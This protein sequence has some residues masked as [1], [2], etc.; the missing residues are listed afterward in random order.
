M[1]LVY[2]SYSNFKLIFDNKLSI[3]IFATYYIYDLLFLLQIGY[4]PIESGMIIATDLVSIL[5]LKCIKN[6]CFSGRLVSSRVIGLAD[7]KSVVSRNLE[8]I[9]EGNQPCPLEIT[10]EYSSSFKT[11]KLNES[12]PSKLSKLSSKHSKPSNVNS[13][14]LDSC[15]NYSKQSQPMFAYNHTNS[16]LNDSI[17][18]DDWKPFDTQSNDA[19]HFE[20]A[21]KIFNRI[22]TDTASKNPNLDLKTSIDSNKYDYIYSM[23]NNKLETIKEF[24]SS[25]EKSSYYTDSMN[26]SNSPDI[27]AINISRQNALISPIQTPDSTTPY[28]QPQNTLGIDQPHFGGSHWDEE[29]QINTMVPIKKN[30]IG[31]QG[32]SDQQVVD[33][34]YEVSFRDLNAFKS[35]HKLKPGFNTYNSLNTKH[36]DPKQVISTQKFDTDHEIYQA[37]DEGFDELD[38]KKEILNKHTNLDLSNLSS[39]QSPHLQNIETNTNNLFTTAPPFKQLLPLNLRNDLFNK[40]AISTDTYSSKETANRELVNLQDETKQKNPI[41][42]DKKELKIRSSKHNTSKNQNNLSFQDVFSAHW[43]RER[44]HDKSYYQN[45]TMSAVDNSSG[46][47]SPVTD[48][49]RIKHSKPKSKSQYVPRKKSCSED[50]ETNRRVSLFNNLTGSTA[51]KTPQLFRKDLNKVKNQNLRTRQRSDD[52]MITGVVMNVISDIISLVDNGIIILDNNLMGIYNNIDALYSKQLIKRSNLDEI[53]NYELL[54]NNRVYTF[55]RIFKKENVTHQTVDFFSFQ[56]ILKIYDFCKKKKGNEW[57]LVNI[58]NSIKKLEEKRNSGLISVYNGEVIEDNNDFKNYKN[59]QQINVIELN[60]LL[61]ALF[62]FQTKSTENGDFMTEN[63]CD[64]IDQFSH[65]S[66]FYKDVSIKLA[67]INLCTEPMLCLT[68]MDLGERV[69]LLN[70][71]DKNKFKN[72]QIS[73]ISHELQTPMNFTFAI[74]DYFIEETRKMQEIFT[75]TKNTNEAT[76]TFIINQ[77]TTKELCDSLSSIKGNSEA[78][79]KNLTHMGLIIQSIVDYSHIQTDQFIMTNESVDIVASI[80]DILKIYSEQTNGKNIFVKVDNPKPT[81]T[82]ITDKKRLDVLLSVIIFNSVKYTMTGKISVNINPEPKLGYLQISVTDTGVGM[83]AEQLKTLK[84]SLTNTLTSKTTTNC[85]GIGL[86][87]RIVATILRYMA[88]KDKNKQE[89]KSE[90]DVGT[91]VTFYLKTGYQ[92]GDIEQG[93]LENTNTDE[94]I[95]ENV[96]P[97]IIMANKMYFKNEIKSKEGA[98]ESS[99]STRQK[100]VS[101]LSP[102][103]KIGLLNENFL[104][105]KNHIDLID[106]NISRLQSPLDMNMDRMIPIALSVSPHNLQHR[107]QKQ[108]FFN[109]AQ[110]I[111]EQ[112]HEINSSDDDAKINII[113]R[114]QKN[115]TKTHTYDNNNY[116]R[117]SSINPYKPTKVK[118]YSGFYV[119][120]RSNPTKSKTQRSFSQFKKESDN[121]LGAF[122]EDYIGSNVI[123]SEETGNNQGK[124]SRFAIS[125]IKRSESEFNEEKSDALSNQNSKNSY[126][127]ESTNGPPIINHKKKNTAEVVVGISQTE[128]NKQIDLKTRQISTDFINNPEI[129]FQVNSDQ[130]KSYDDLHKNEDK[131]DTGNAKILINTIN[132]NGDGIDESKDITVSPNKSNSYFLTPTNKDN[133]LIELL[134]PMNQTNNSLKQKHDETQTFFNEELA[135]SDINNQ[136]Y[137]QNAMKLSNTSESNNDFKFDLEG[138]FKEKGLVLN[139]TNSI[140]LEETLQSNIPFSPKTHLSNQIHQNT[141][142]L[143]FNTDKRDNNH[144]PIQSKHEQIKQISKKSGDDTVKQIY[145][146]QEIV[147]PDNKIKLED[148]TIRKVNTV[149]SNNP[150]TSEKYFFVYK[151]NQVYQRMQAS[152]HSFTCR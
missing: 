15:E 44:R 34:R 99:L 30:V 55:N 84:L 18:G 47:N 46:F 139:K 56:T 71:D 20:L 45:F 129:T 6:C 29:A 62:Q 68:I 57:F 133:T 114:D 58:E 134:G 151:K 105:T 35:A 127:N 130:E 92:I 54:V 124:H 37:D 109:K 108:I 11:K 128:K 116:Q 48:S 81:V 86:G 73:S 88:P 89:F 12:D 43:I 87:L 23:N 82:W 140:L 98:I 7:S 26:K 120:N 91:T 110:S 83:S 75:D 74:M 137:L 67:F 138:I 22:N 150:G 80:K 117:N 10:P 36:T 96:I 66:F 111:K 39:S 21:K 40:P 9:V 77:S 126:S 51:S 148:A 32:I 19:N 60:H 63:E 136:N 121:T 123:N 90:K 143:L 61:S 94:S 14:P 119:P 52:S 115:K 152:N 49:L 25:I 93:H 4:F 85:S 70:L 100:S 145:S 28:Y 78:V 101:Q 76:G 17:Y 131:R 142:S 41:N 64:L 106:N 113:K 8:A 144:I 125:N 59:I 53:F 103:D 31:N 107:L 102:F 149:E 13:N 27:N 33:S 146:F 50:L 95:E 79:L 24:H 69:L 97:K 65:I 147:K 42:F 132:N 38:L 118:K 5:N 104:L 122:V 16:Q 141:S 112:S 135:I 2:Y 3:I 1:L 72:Q